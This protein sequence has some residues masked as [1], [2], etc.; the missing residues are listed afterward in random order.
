MEHNLPAL[1]TIGYVEKRTDPKPEEV[2]FMA[3]LLSNG[4]SHTPTV[5]NKY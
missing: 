5:G 3:A 2:F 4:I 1:R